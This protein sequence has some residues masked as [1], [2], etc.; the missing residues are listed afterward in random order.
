MK[1]TYRI[2]DWDKHFENHQ[3]RK[4]KRQQWVAVP[5]QHD[6]KS[7][8]R[9][10]AHSD[11]VQVFAAW[12]LML[13]AA[14]KMPVRGVLA[15]EDGPLDAEDLASMTGFPA[16]IFTAAFELLT[17]DKIGWLS[18]EEPKLRKRRSPA[19]SRNVP[20]PPA[21][22]RDL[23]A[24]AATSRNF[25]QSP[26]APG[27][28]AAEGNGTEGNGSEPKGTEDSAKAGASAEGQKQR[29]Q[30]FDIWTL[31]VNKLIATGTEERDARSFLGKQRKEFGGETVSAAITKM[32][33]QNPVDPK[34]YLVAV[35]QG[36]NGTRHGPTKADQS[37]AAAGRVAA[38]YE[39]RG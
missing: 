35:L 16:A 28:S 37:L 3:S 25:P 17:Q 38:K 8:R 23:P 26:A 27:E 4:V 9:I 34:A 6:G 29:Q 2:K 30:D 15:D 13:E 31:G 7:F 19:T 33:A 1:P 14:S 18:A 21:I 11:G 20:Q 12:V 36:Q 22:S 39:Q 32:L 10:A 24:S 5:N